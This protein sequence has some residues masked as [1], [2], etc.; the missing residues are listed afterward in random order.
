MFEPDVADYET[1]LLT[2]ATDA[3]EYDIQQF[4]VTARNPYCGRT[5][6]EAFVELKDSHNVILIG[7]SKAKGSGRVL[8]KLPSD[9]VA[10]EEGDYLL[11]VL[12]GSSEAA[13]SEM[14]HVR[15]GM[16]DVA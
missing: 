9:D 2:S 3:G 6:G 5:Y 13:I 8:I 11:M 16:L 14:F 4:R 1:D 12:G 10:V 7:I 15:Q